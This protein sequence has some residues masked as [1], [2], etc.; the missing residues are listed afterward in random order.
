MRLT[1]HPLQDVGGAKRQECRCHA[2]QELLPTCVCWLLCVGIA[3]TGGEEGE[4]LGGEVTWGAR[5]KE[6]QQD[7]PSIM[8][9]TQL[10]QVAL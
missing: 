6:V 3:V 8:V 2:L 5:G 9:L 7:T 4:E 10:R 1:S